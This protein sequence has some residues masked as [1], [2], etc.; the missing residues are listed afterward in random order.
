MS[1]IDAI[2]SYKKITFEYGMKTRFC[3]R[4]RTYTP[5]VFGHLNSLITQTWSYDVSTTTVHSHDHLTFILP[6]KDY[7]ET[8]KL[9]A[10]KDPL[11]CLNVIIV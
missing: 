1:Q 2:F 7:I 10:I 3:S 6:G 9:W 11:I 8:T 5:V 4:P